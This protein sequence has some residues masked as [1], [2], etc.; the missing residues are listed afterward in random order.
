PAL[1]AAKLHYCLELGEIQQA[2][3]LAKT[4]SQRP[5][6]NL[7]NLQREQLSLTRL[8]LEKQHFDQARNTL[9]QVLVTAR[10]QGYIKLEIQA[11]ILLSLTLDA[12]KER[13]PARQVF[14]QALEL[15]EKTQSIRLFSDESVQLIN[16]FNE[17]PLRSEERRVGTEGR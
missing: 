11:L 4:I 5:S 8:Q 6:T 12:M 9:D 16:F 13:E 3:A 7:L 14:S 2:E 1:Q 10:E 17:T 15:A